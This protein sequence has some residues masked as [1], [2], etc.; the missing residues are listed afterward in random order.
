VP[1]A[2]ATAG[3]LCAALGERVFAELDA[4]GALAD[5]LARF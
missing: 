1:G 4:S 3:A 2:I 5:S